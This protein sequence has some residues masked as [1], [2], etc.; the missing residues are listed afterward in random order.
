MDTVKIQKGSTRMIAHRGVSGLEKENTL[1]AFI[2]AGNRSY[3]GVETDVHRTLDGQYVVI[4]DDTTGRVCVDDMTVEKTTFE[5]LRGLKLCD[6]DGEKGRTD[7]RIPTLLEYIRLCRKYEKV[8][9]LEFKGPFAKEH[10]VEM[11]ALFEKERYQDRVIFISFHMQNLVY[12][13]EAFP[14]AQAQFLTSKYTGAMVEELL[15]YRLDLD[16]LFTELTK[17]RIAELHDQGIKVNCWTVND[18]QAGQD[19]ADW[20]V[21]FITSNIL[22]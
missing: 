22:E 13:K 15:K 12:L 4:H 1:A 18:A 2:A 5:C 9:V 7:L 21:D 6:L 14:R 8:C 19:L 17:E 16:I 11:A 10:I 3:F 20:G